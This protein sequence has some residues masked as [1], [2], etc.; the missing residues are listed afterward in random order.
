MKPVIGPNDKRTKI[1]VVLPF[2][3]NGEAAFDENGKAVGGRDAVTFSLPRFDFMPR[4]QFKTMMSTIDDITKADDGRTEHDRSYDV[5]LATLR[6][7]IDDATFDLLADMPMGV[8]EQI[9]TDWNEGSSIPLGQLRASTG[10]SKNTK[11]RSTTTSSDMD[12]D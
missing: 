3:A 4:T 7:F 2:T 9:S 1:M 11:V 6:P 12:S 8:L 10:S 5:I